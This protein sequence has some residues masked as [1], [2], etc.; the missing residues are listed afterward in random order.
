[1]NQ[2]DGI[3]RLLAARD[4][5]VLERMAIGSRFAVE[6]SLAGAHRS[7]RKG[8]SIEFADRRPY[9]PGDDTRHL[10]WKVFARSERLSLRQYE[11][12]TSLRLL[13]CVDC[14]ASMGYAG[15]GDS[16]YRYAS[17]C[18]AALAYMTLKR[19]DNV[20]LL[21]FNDQQQDYLQPGGTPEHLRRLCNLL[22]DC[23]P[24]GQT[25]LGPPLHRLAEANPRRSLIA[26]FSDCFGEL[27]ELR[28]A[29]AHFRRQRHDVIL[30]QILDRDETDFPFRDP[31]VFHDPEDD[32]ELTVSPA[33]IRQSYQEQFGTFLRQSRELCAALNVD[34]QQ[35][36]TDE[37]PMQMLTRHLKRRAL[38]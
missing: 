36:V 29:L 28:S 16:K 22:G 30:Y 9:V 13:L 38:L 4:L 33:D 24:Q 31:T 20:G 10:D 11:E 15:E 2:R 3:G 25:S 32:T 37:S 12:E 23:R 5:A 8:I 7:P 18:A 1:M 14:S 17:R 19:Q 6:G 34:Y 26:I 21:L 35:V 27:E